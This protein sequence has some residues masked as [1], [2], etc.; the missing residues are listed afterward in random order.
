MPR[1]SLSYPQ[2]P[3]GLLLSSPVQPIVI[4]LSITLV[5]G[6]NTKVSLSSKVSAASWQLLRHN[7][8]NQ[9]GI[10][11]HGWGELSTSLSIWRLADYVR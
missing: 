11:W 6:A 2:L 10:A 1:S 7:S 9:R 3:A 8:T 5:Q 4:W